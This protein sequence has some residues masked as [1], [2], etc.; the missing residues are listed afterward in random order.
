MRLKNLIPCIPD[1]SRGRLRL[2]QT[3]CSGIQFFLMIRVLV[4][5]LGN[6]LFRAC[7]IFLPAGKRPAHYRGYFRDQIRRG[8]FV[9][10]FLR[11][12]LEDA[13]FVRGQSLVGFRLI[14]LGR[15]FMS[16]QWLLLFQ[17]A[18]DAGLQILG[19]FLARLQPGDYFSGRIKRRA[20]LWRKRSFRIQPQFSCGI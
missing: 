18:I 20:R 16:F 9:L 4:G 7:G 11:P 10:L 5:A 13:L 3:Q 19:L 17:Q 6:R 14:P 8:S 15:V 12:E 2:F 1:G